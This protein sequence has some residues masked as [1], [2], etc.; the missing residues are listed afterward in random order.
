M[1]GL[2]LLAANRI[3]S[4]DEK[5]ITASTSQIAA[6]TSRPRKPPAG[7]PEK[8]RPMIKPSSSN[9]TAINTISRIEFRLLALINSHIS[10]RSM[11][12]ALAVQTNEASFSDCVTLESH[13]RCFSAS[14]L[15]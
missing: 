13:Y 9:T 6:A 10:S 11:P 7:S 2:A 1:T 14:L 8:L 5:L 15:C 4:P 3:W 12:P